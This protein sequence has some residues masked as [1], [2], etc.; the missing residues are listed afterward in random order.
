MPIYEYYCP[1]CKT[2]TEQLVSLTSTELTTCVKCHSDELERI[3]SGTF[4][5][6]GLS[7][8]GKAVPK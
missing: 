6:S 5:V 3:Y 2:Y 7:T 8:P 4:G 1:K